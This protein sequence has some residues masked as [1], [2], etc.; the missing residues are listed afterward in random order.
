MIQ[1]RVSEAAALSIVE[2]ADYYRQV[3]D[4]ALASRWETTIDEAARS[5]LNYPDRGALCR[6]RNPVLESLRWIPVSG[7]PRH[8]LFYCY[9]PAQQT[10]LI[11]QVL[12]GARDLHTVLD[13]EP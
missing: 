3:A 13:E 12:H 1:L 11:V 7:F 4:A 6:F 10:V 5:L 9:S 8:M 2:Q